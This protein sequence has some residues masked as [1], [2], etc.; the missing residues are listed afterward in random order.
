[1]AVLKDILEK[2]RRHP[3]P[4][5]ADNDELGEWMEELAEFDGHIAGLAS[6]QLGGE[7]VDTSGLSEQMNDLFLQ[8]EDIRG[9]SEKDSA[10]YNECSTY[11]KIIQGL[12]AL[13]LDS[14]PH[15]VL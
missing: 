2:M 4:E 1:V 7:V 11:L 14:Q 3:F 10:I 12:V 8:F 15:R 6:S 5:F 9:L 13:L